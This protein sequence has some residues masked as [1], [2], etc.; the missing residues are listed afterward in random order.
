VVTEH[1]TA[2]SSPGNESGVN[3]LR[4]IARTTKT[5]LSRGDRFRSIA[6]WLNVLAA[7]SV[8]LNPI[9]IVLLVC[10]NPL[11]IAWVYP[12][13]LY[14]LHLSVLFPSTPAVGCGMGYPVPNTG[15]EYF[16]RVN[17][18]ISTD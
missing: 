16:S 17:I 1:R 11:G 2:V 13:V 8:A 14:I 18:Y 15:S 4:S 3:G 10:F 7:V 6:D 5:S 12:E 9:A